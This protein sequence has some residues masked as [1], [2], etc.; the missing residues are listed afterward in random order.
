M[1]FGSIFT[2]ISW[3]WKFFVSILSIILI[4]FILSGDNAVL[5]AMAVRKLPKNQRRKGIAFGSGVAVVLRIVLTFFVAKLLQIAFLKLI[6]GLLILWIAVKLFVDGGGEEDPEKA[7]GTLWQAIR[8]IVFADLTMSLDNV[9]AVAGA[10]HGN[11]S[12]LIF[13]LVLS[14]PIVVFTSNLLSILMDKFPIIILLGAALLGWVGGE[15]ILTD[16]FIEKWIHPG[17]IV[18]YSIQLAFAVGVVM[19]GKIWLRWRFSKLAQDPETQKKMVDL[20]THSI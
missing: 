5:I 8:L 19:T 20:S 17:K 12:L 13:G 18:E 4:N 10:S 1:D 14:V 11:L 3:D 7:A 9:L 2:N 15:M 6:G 16:P